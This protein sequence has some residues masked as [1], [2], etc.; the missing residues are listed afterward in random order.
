[1]AQEIRNEE[2][3]HAPKVY[4]SP[5]IDSADVLANEVVASDEQSRKSPIGERHS[6]HP[7]NYR[8]D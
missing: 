7:R 1:M 5:A 2:V 8:E 6:P 3:Q 4:P